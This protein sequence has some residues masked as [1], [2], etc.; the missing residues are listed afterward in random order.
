MIT[1]ELVIMGLVEHLLDLDAI[2]YTD[3]QHPGPA[4][5]DDLQKPATFIAAMDQR[6]TTALAISLYNED[7]QRDDHNPDFYVQLRGRALGTDPLAVEAMMQR[8]FQIL[9]WDET[10]PS[11]TWPNGAEIQLSRRVSRTQALPDGKGNYERY[12]SYRLTVNPKMGN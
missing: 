12:D 4:Y 3:Q 2:Q 11:E 1:P 5:T 8:F 7:R 10:H 9:H 6:P